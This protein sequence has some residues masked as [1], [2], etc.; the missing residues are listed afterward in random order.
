MPLRDATRENMIYG[1]D[2]EK[3]P[4]APGG[5]VFGRRFSAAF[6]ALYVGKADHNIRARVKR[7]LNNLRL[8]QHL[9][10]AKGGKRMLLAGR[11]AGRPGQQSANVYE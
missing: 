1:V 2:L 10:K 6:E 9:K 3:L 8:M 5:Y 7:Q 4:S 11:F